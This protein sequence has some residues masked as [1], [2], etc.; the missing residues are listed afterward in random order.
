[1][2]K[3]RCKAVLSLIPIKGLK[4]FLSNLKGRL[5]RSLEA[6]KPPLAAQTS[7]LIHN[8]ILAHQL[9]FLKKSVIIS[10]QI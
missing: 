7:P 1:L 6:P 5:S 3:A 8:Y 2:E 9:L 4:F 10:W